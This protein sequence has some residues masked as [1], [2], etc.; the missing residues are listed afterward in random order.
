MWNGYGVCSNLA[1][2]G[3]PPASHDHFNHW[4]QPSFAAFCLTVSCIE[5]IPEALGDRSWV[6]KYVDFATLKIAQESK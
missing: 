2:S 3:E 6:W 4:P 5:I 1:S